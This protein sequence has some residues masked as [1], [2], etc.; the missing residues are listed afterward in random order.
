MSDADRQWAY[1]RLEPMPHARHP[2]DGLWRANW[3]HILAVSA[4]IV[5][6][7]VAVG[8]VAISAGV[9]Q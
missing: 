8:L 1:G 6:G 2:S 3:L 7:I 5:A 4:T 9:G